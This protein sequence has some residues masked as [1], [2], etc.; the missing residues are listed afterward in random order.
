MCLSI[1]RVPLSLYGKMRPPTLPPKHIQV[2]EGGLQSQ[3]ASSCNEQPALEK[4]H[5]CNHNSLFMVLLTIFTRCRS[6]VEKSYPPKKTVSDPLS[7]Y[8][9]KCLGSVVSMQAS[10][11]SLRRIGRS[12]AP[13]ATV[14]RKLHRASSFGYSWGKG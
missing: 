9:Y 3:S 1:Y 14:L 2:P 5:I 7:L 11:S 10:P 4:D 6:E 13:L 12:F 8:W